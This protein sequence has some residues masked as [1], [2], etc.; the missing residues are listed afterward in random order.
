MVNDIVQ[1]TNYDQ[2]V[3]RSILV[4]R[5]SYAG[6]I[7]VTSTGSPA[8]PEIM[9]NV[10]H[11]RYIDRQPD[12][13]GTA[14]SGGQLFELF[15][16][17]N[18]TDAMRNIEN[19]KWY[20]VLY[21]KVWPFHNNYT[22]ASGQIG[23]YTY[24]GVKSHKFFKFHVKFRRPIKVTFVDDPEATQQIAQ[25]DIL[26]SFF[27]PTTSSVADEFY[28]QLTSLTMRTVYSDC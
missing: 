16:G 12:S 25:N 15:V 9:E 2:R 10:R 24:S 13:S 11:L 20:K 28:P 23:F 4:H 7:R 21:D 22:Q 26:V 6:T 1:G 17:Q 18:T 19:Y 5:I 14:P 3:G 8:D 27:G